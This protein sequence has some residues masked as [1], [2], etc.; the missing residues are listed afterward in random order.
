MS[1]NVR[2]QEEGG[3]RWGRILVLGDKKVLPVVAHQDSCRETE[4]FEVT[5]I[6]SN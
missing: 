1:E 6:S 5:T 2:V 4:T 3:K